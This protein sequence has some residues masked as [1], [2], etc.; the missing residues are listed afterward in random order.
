[1]EVP[2]LKG[3]NSGTLYREVITFVTAQLAF[4]S[5][6]AR[7]KLRFLPPNVFSL[8]ARLGKVLPLKQACLRSLLQTQIRP[9]PGLGTAPDGLPQQVVKL[10]LLL[11]DRDPISLATR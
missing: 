9:S 4:G 6:R 2:F 3:V 10:G 11:C 1:M 8:G 7:S 5:R